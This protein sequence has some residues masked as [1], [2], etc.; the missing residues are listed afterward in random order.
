MDRGN[1]GDQYLMN[2]NGAIVKCTVTDVYLDTDGQMRVKLKDD[3]VKRVI[4][5]H[6]FTIEEINNTD[7]FRRVNAA[8][9]EKK[10][11]SAKA[12]LRFEPPT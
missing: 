11:K 6:I 12:P 3:G 4:I 9:L 2:K 1:I 10:A 7:V 8:V 5:E